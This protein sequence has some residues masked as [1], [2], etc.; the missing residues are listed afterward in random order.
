M[1]YRNGPARSYFKGRIHLVDAV[2]IAF[3]YY[4]IY[5][6][7][8]NAYVCM[9]V[10]CWTKKTTHQR[11]VIDGI[12]GVEVFQG[13]G[14]WPIVECSA[15]RPQFVVG[16]RLAS[17]EQRL[18]GGGLGRRQW[19]RRRLLKLAQEQRAHVGGCF[20]RQLQHLL[21]AGVRHT[22][23]VAVNVVCHAQ[24]REPVSPVDGNGDVGAAVPAPVDRA[25]RRDDKVTGLLL[26][27]RKRHV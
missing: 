7:P 3:L 13:G 20:S 8:E 6:L 24:A 23:R 2:N 16:L 17:G 26:V 10:G 21:V 1:L 4:L 15:R 27:Q 19:R 18:G 14:A 5:C 25:R 9:C 22:T 12:T 11:T